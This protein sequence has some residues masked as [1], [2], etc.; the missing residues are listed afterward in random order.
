VYRYSVLTAVVSEL[1]LFDEVSSLFLVLAL[2][3]EN[4]LFVLVLLLGIG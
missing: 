1:E 3:C 2:D 4:D